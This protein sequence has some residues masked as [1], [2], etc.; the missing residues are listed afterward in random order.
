[1]DIMSVNG[2]E[3]KNGGTTRTIKQQIIS[4]LK[5][6]PNE[7]FT[8]SEIRF[9]LSYMSDK[10]DYWDFI[11]NVAKTM[12]LCN[13]LEELEIKGDIVVKSMKNEIQLVLLD[14]IMPNMAGIETFRELRKIDPEVK[15]ILISGFSQDGK[16]TELMKDGAMGFIQKPFSS[17]IL[18]N[19]ISG[20]L[21]K[22]PE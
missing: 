15:V 19:I 21:K 3:W 12:L 20:T 1:M 13:Y 7:A 4:Y 14:M 9:G 17:K 2:E 10:P 8:E 11:C 5:N 22:Q 18:V 6:N 16:V